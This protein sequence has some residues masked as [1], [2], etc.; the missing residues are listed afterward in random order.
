M[1]YAKTHENNCPSI[2]RVVR[3]ELPDGTTITANEGTAVANRFGVA[4]PERIW[5][6]FEEKCDRLLS[7]YAPADFPA[8]ELF[9]VAARLME[10]R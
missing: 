2:F 4:L 3:C 6:S 10:V 7:F 1:T 8:D 9:D 5:E